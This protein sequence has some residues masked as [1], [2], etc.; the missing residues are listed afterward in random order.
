MAGPLSGN[1]P[2]NARAV[3]VPHLRIEVSRSHELGVRALL[4]DSPLVEHA[5]HV[6]IHHRREPMGHHE[7][8]LALREHGERLLDESLV[9]RISERRRFVEHDYRSVFEDR[10]GKGDALALA[11]RQIDAARAHH[12]IEP[13][14][15][16][17]Q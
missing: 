10:P 14:G 5:D 9:F 8:R 1:P 7:H 6:G 15:K 2:R 13:I 4:D 3:I 16:T 17:W 11:T 12:G